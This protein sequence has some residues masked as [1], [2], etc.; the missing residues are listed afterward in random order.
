MLTPPP[1]GYMM[2]PLALPQRSRQVSQ[3]DNPQ[4]RGTTSPYPYHSAHVHTAAYSI[5]TASQ[6]YCGLTNL[7]AQLPAAAGYKVREEGRR[8]VHST[9]TI[10]T[11]M[12][13]E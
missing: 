8:R 12:S 7:P 2:A 5:Q 9:Y 3:H 11:G 6:H 1:T 10:Y 4:L 13:L